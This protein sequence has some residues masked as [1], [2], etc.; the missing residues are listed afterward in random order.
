M[1]STELNQYLHAVEQNLTSLDAAE[2][3]EIIA[4]I[5]EHFHSVKVAE[6]HRSDASIIADLGNPTEIGEAA[7][8]APVTAAA[9]IPGEDAELARH[10]QKA[11]HSLILVAVSLFLSFT[12]V[13]PL[14]ATPLGLFW[15]VQV[16]RETKA[17]KT[18]YNSARGRAWIAVVAHAAI[19]LTILIATIGAIGMLAATS[20]IETGPVEIMPA[21]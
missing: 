3:H 10:T 1:K 4:G 6:P 14:I 13:A 15:S 17:E 8:H 20:T 2:R 21:G 19:M 7:G 9:N 18:R 11:N 12:L 5:I 16:L